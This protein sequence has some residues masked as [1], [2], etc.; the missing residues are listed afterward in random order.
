MSIRICCLILVLGSSPVAAQVGLQSGVAQVALIA[1][2]APGGSIRAVEPP[3]QTG[4]AGR[5]V[6]ASAVVQWSANTGY[7]LLVRGGVPTYRVWV[8]DLNGEY[9]ELTGAAS[10]TV[11]R[12]QHG[13]GQ[14]ERVV[15]YRIELPE[16]AELTGPLPLRYEIAINPSI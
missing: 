11:A 3:R 1:R 6:E 8:Q 5:I 9:Q 7:R 2:T 16:N 10:V 15:R 13:A 4:R 14:W 12:G